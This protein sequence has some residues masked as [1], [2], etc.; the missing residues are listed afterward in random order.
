[1]HSIFLVP[2]AIFSLEN[3]VFSKL[4]VINFPYIIEF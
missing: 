2:N 4:E 1:M 3:A